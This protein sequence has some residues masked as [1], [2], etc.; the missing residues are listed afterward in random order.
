M[1]DTSNHGVVWCTSTFQT[2]NVLPIGVHLKAYMSLSCEC[3]FHSPFSQWLSFSYGFE[4]I[5]VALF[6]C[7]FMLVFIFQVVL[8]FLSLVFFLLIQYPCFVVFFWRCVFLDS[9]Q[10]HISQR[11]ATGCIHVGTWPYF[12]YYLVCSVMLHNF[13]PRFEPHGLSS[14]FAL[15]LCLCLLMLCVFFCLHV[16]RNG[17][18]SRADLRHETQVVTTGREQSLSSAVSLTYSWTSRCHT[19]ILDSQTCPSL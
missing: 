18:R 2:M 1:W 19:F 14:I 10:W 17:L 3:I 8:Q 11:F 6:L 16:W 7:L 13:F 15:V 5:Y 12:C 4:C 9:R